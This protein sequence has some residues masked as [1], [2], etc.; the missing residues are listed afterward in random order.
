LCGTILE[1][2]EPDRVVLTWNSSID[3][4][5]VYKNTLSVTIDDKLMGSLRG[6]K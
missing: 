6:K 3:E 2:N 5:V 4:M 1:E